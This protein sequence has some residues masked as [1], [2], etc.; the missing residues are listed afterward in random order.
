MVKGNNPKVNC[1]HQKCGENAVAVWE[2]HDWPIWK[3]K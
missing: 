1:H 2:D 3:G